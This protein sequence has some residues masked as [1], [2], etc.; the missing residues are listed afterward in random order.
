TT[1]PPRQPH[2]EA[3]C[4]DFTAYTTLC[5][6]PTPSSAATRNRMSPA[7]TRSFPSTRRPEKIETA[8]SN[9]P[10]RTAYSKERVRWLISP[11]TLRGR[12]RSEG[13]TFASP[14]ARVSARRTGKALSRVPSVRESRTAAERARSPRSGS[15]F[16]VSTDSPYARAAGRAISTGATFAS[17]AARPARIAPSASPPRIASPRAVDHAGAGEAG[18][19]PSIAGA[20]KNLLL[21]TREDT[22]HHIRAAAPEPVGTARWPRGSRSGAA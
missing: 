5:P 22:N 3:I 16:A 18:I 6:P 17:T 10:V 15:R 1:S 7:I 12:R 2:A 14:A 8:A 13:R 19:P 9:A 11:E 20:K 21:Q 4:H